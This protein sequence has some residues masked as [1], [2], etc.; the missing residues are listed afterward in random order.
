MALAGGTGCFQW[1]FVVYA[2]SHAAV[3]QTARAAGRLAGVRFVFYVAPVLLTGGCN[4]IPVEIQDQ[5]FIQGFSTKK[6]DGRGRGFGLDIVKA[7][8]ESY[9][10]HVYVESPVKNSRFSN[11]SNSNPG[12]KFTLIFPRA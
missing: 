1:S 4:G 12:T 5:I 8:T 2:V 9:G 6:S 7:Y 10:G 11:Q 3:G